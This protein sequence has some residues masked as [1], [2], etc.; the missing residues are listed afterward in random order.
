MG[1]IRI[2]VGIVWVTTKS[3]SEDDFKS[4]LTGK[5]VTVDVAPNLKDGKNRIFRGDLND[6]ITRCKLD[7][8]ISN[9]SVIHFCEIPASYQFLVYS[10]M[11]PS[12]ISRS[13][14][15]GPGSGPA[16]R[17]LDGTHQADLVLDFQRPPPSLCLP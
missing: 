3:F 9:T 8:F 16:N 1:L 6:T 10:T 2:L 14:L 13:S 5:I 12:L 7:H 17:L 11:Y 15:Q 4:S